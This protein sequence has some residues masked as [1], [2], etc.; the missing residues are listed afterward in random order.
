[1]QAQVP[2]WWANIGASPTRLTED[3]YVAAMEYK[4]RSTARGSSDTVGGL[5]V[6]H[7]ALFVMVDAEGEADSSGAWPVHEVGRNADI[8]DAEAGRLLE[9]GSALAFKVRVPADFGDKELVWTLTSNRDDRESV[10]V[11]AIRLRH[12]QAGHSG[13]RR[14]HVSARPA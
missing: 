4:E 14:D 11:A 5:F 8:F 12:R 3:R 13:E 7:H 9:A 2:D 1:M 6:V 10:R